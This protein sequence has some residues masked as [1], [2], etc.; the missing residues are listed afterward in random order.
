MFFSLTEASF[1]LFARLRILDSSGK[2]SLES[3]IFFLSPVSVTISIVWFF[4]FD[5][6]MLFRRTAGCKLVV[7]IMSPADEAALVGV[8][9]LLVVVEAGEM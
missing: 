8:V 7:D 6:A 5:S 2:D 1:W 4:F 3:E 9:E